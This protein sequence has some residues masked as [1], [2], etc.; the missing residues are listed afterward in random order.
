MKNDNY[1]AILASYTSSILQDF[2]FYLRR[3]VDLVEDDIRLVLVEYKSR[4]FTFH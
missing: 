2:E 3:E 4:F 1:M